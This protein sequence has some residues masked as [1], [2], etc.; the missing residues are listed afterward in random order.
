[1]LPEANFYFLFNVML[2]SLMC[3][4]VWWFHFIIALVVRIATGQTKGV[5]DTREYATEKE[6]GAPHRVKN[7]H[8]TN[9]TANKKQKAR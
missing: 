2:W 1:M 3:L 4:N 5:E 7:G 9:G 8:A 6:N